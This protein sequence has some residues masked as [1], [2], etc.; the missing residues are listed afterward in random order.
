MS[1]GRS[2]WRIW[3]A[4]VLALWL[5][6]FLLAPAP[7]P[8]VPLARPTE[9]WELPLP[10]ARLDM[11]AAAGAMAT[12]PVWG[13]RPP[14]GAAVAAEDTRWTI[15]GIFLRAGD[16]AQAVVRF[17]ATR[18]TQTVTIGDELP[19]G[20]KVESIESSRVCVRAGRKRE[21]LAVPPVRPPGF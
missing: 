12:S 7:V 19:D 11:S 16:P 9:R 21:C 13:A 6:V 18:P 10:P 17:A 1:Q 2:V 15:A 14:A 5:A 20:S 4:G 3:V 8:P